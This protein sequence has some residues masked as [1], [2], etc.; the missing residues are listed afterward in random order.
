MINSKKSKKQRNHQDFFVFLI[1][2]HDKRPNI[3]N[4]VEYI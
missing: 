4:S 2:L 3:F 1:L